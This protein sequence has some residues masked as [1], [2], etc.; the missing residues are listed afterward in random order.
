MAKCQPLRQVL[1]P[2]NFAR[3]LPGMS[4]E[5]VRKML[6]K[7]MKITPYALARTTQYDWRY[8]DPPNTPMVFTAVFDSDL[9]VLSTGSVLEESI[10]PGNS[11]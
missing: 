5:Q 3:V 8:I 10:N 9:R 1:N 2:Q 6:G 7:P 11:R 4:M